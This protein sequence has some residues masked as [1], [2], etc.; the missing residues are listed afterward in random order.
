M[1]SPLIAL[2]L[3]AAA[4]AA[5]AQ[6]APYATIGTVS[7]AVTVSGKDLMVTATPGMAL[8]QGTSVVTSNAGTATVLF[9]SG[10]SVALKPGQMMAVQESEC[11]AIQ[12]KRV[13]TGAGGS[14]ATGGEG[15]GTPT[16]VLIGVGT[17]GAI[18]IYEA[19]KS[20]SG[21]T[22]ATPTPPGATPPAVTPPRRPSFPSPSQGPN[23]PPASRS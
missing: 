16:G 18:A 19:F 22:A 15:E 20:D 1:K 9:A 21:T 12:A 11:S 5:L 13:G 8:K 7:G 6:N 17:V 10:C 2:T 14:A 23:R 3:V 4:G